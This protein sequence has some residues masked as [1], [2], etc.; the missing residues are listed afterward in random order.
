MAEYPSFTL[1]TV[2]CRGVAVF[3]L[4]GQSLPESNALVPTWSSV[5]AKRITTSFRLGESYFKAD[6]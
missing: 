5:S 6:L 3:M 2:Y 1:H 4:V